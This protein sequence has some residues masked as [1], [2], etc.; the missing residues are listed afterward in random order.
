MA[1]KINNET[2]IQDDTRVF[3]NGCTFITEQLAQPGYDNSI[4]GW[5]M[6]GMAYATAGIYDH[7]WAKILLTNNPL[8]GYQIGDVNGNGSVDL[9]DS[10]DITKQAIGLRDLDDSF[11][12]VNRFIGPASIEYN[13]PD[14]SA[15]GYLVGFSDEDAYRVLELYVNSG[16]P[17]WVTKA[18][19]DSN[20]AAYADID[21]SGSINSSDLTAARNVINRST[22]NVAQNAN[23]YKFKGLV[24]GK[25]FKADSTSSSALWGRGLVG[26]GNG[27]HYVKGNTDGNN[28]TS[29][30]EISGYKVDTEN[31]YIHRSTGNNTAPAIA[32]YGLNGLEGA[33]ASGDNVANI[34]LTIPESMRLSAANLSTALR[35]D[36]HGYQY[37]N[38]ANLWID[39]QNSS[40][41]NYNVWNNYRSAYTSYNTGTYVSNY[42]SGIQTS[43]YGYWRSAQHAFG[44]SMYLYASTL[45]RC[46]FKVDTNHM[47]NGGYP[48]QGVAVGNIDY[49]SIPEK[50]R[51]RMNTGNVSMRISISVF[52][53]L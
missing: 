14:T 4:A 6:K 51:F 3:N 47:Y 42:A 8:T 35:V 37:T 7:P 29:V 32:R 11:F 22:N 18:F 21:D 1:Y 30:H 46:S 48:M 33:S 36:Y 38:G 49:G 53:G 12:F 10:L 26:T 39:P 41:T 50:L 34:T 13:L 44:G 23:F 25:F 17:S 28:A 16:T 9:S 40:G 31:L 19:T 2:L 20:I 5:A 24:C 45:G 27:F 15:G 43:Y 52:G